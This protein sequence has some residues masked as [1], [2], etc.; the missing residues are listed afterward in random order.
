MKQ[1]VRY[2]AGL[3]V[4]AVLMLAAG[5]DGKYVAER[6]M[7]RDGQSFTIIQ[8]FDLKAEGPKLTGK[9]SMQFG[10]MEPRSMDIADGKVDGNKFSF[11]TTMDTPN[12][13]MKMS[14]KGTVDGDTLKGESQR[15]GGEPRAFEAKRK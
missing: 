3:T 7:E 4:T 12:G 8:T 5:V 10:D 13:T 15:E 11:N 1:L 9:V 2:F 6:K 14:Y